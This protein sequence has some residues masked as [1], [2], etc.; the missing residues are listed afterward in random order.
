MERPSATFCHEK[1]I[2]LDNLRYAEF[3]AYYTLENKS[4]I[5][6][7][8]EPDELDDNLIEITMKNVLIPKKLN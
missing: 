8:F 2:I 1:Y 5:T 7:E 6:G 3:S 4:S